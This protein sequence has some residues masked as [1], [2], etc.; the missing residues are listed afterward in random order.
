MV[1]SASDGGTNPPQ[2]GAG[3]AFAPQGV[4]RVAVGN[5]GL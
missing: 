2:H 5:S 3:F 1:S 4:M